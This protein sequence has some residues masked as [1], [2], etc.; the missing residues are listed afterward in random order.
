MGTYNPHYPRIIGQEWVPIRDTNYTP[1]PAANAIE[2]GHTFQLLQDRQVRDAR[3]Y[4]NTLPSA[5]NWQAF[6]A[7]VYRTGTEAATGP[8]KSVIIPCNFASTTGGSGVIL[9]GPSNAAALAWPNDDKVI[10]FNGAGNQQMA[11]FFNIDPYIQLLTNKRILDVQFLFAGDAHDNITQNPIG[12]PSPG[13][14]LASLNIANDANFNL[15]S[16]CDLTFLLSGGLGGNTR[17]PISAVSLG[18]VTDPLL[19]INGVQPWRFIDLQRFQSGSANRFFLIIRSNMSANQSI[20]WQYAALQ[21]IYCEERRLMVGGTANENGSFAPLLGAQVLPMRAIQTQTT[22]PVL[23]AGDYTVTLSAANFGNRLKD[24]TSSASFPLL[25]EVRQLYEIPTHRGVQVNIPI[26]VEDHLEATFGQESTQFLPQISLH[27]SGGP[28]T[29][30]HVYGR[31]AQAQVWGSISATQEIQDGLA[32]GNASWPW[33]RFYARRFGNTTRPLL[34]DSPSIGGSSVQITPAEFDALDEIAAGWKEVTLRFN[35]PPVMGSGTQPQWRWTASGENAGDRWEVL[36]AT[37]P[38]ISGLPGNLLNTVLS[39][40]QLSI[41]TYGQPVSGSSINLGWVPQ[42]APP[43]SATVDDQ[44]SDAT[45]IFAQEMTAPT[46]F[47]VAGADQAMVGIG[48]NCGINP[49]CIPSSIRYNTISWTPFSALTVRDTFERTVANGWGTADT[50]QVYALSG[51]ATSFSVGSGEGTISLNSVGAP[52]YATLPVAQADVDIRIDKVVLGGGITPAGAPIGIGLVARFVNNVNWYSARLVHNTN[53]TTQLELDKMVAGVRTVLATSTALPNVTPGGTAFTMRFQ[54]IGSMLRAKAW[55]RN[56]GFGVE[57]TAWTVVAY[58][59][60]FTAGG[61]IGVL[62]NLE[63]GNSNTLPVTSNWNDLTET[64]LTYDPDS[65][66]YMELQRMDTIDTTWTTIMK[67]TNLMVSG[68]KDYEARVG[69][70]SSYRLR[71][72]DVLGFT[73]AWSSTQSITMARPGASGGCISPGHLLMFTTNERQDGS[74]NLAYSSAWER[75]VEEGFTFPEA[76]FVQLQ[77]MYNRDF[78]TAFR[79]TERGGEQ[80]ER[81]ILVQAAAISPPTLADFTS[82]RDMAWEDVSYICV[83]DEDGNRWFATVLVP[84]G[85]VVF[86]RRIYMATVQIIEVTDT[87]SEVNP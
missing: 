82:L 1:S 73:G 57:P 22:D 84:S 39:P 23:S 31:Q 67:A 12:D 18:E 13:V 5:V 85:K 68:F 72:V 58:D 41:A 26:P 46:G 20:S 75:Q 7:Q 14:G 76:G 70:Q 81:D 59:T 69:I 50:G 87:P 17:T 10:I 56:G 6:T 74:S 29:E 43:T 42:Y 24:G 9:V 32:G 16:Y 47:T 36:G 15:V 71:F 25:N 38:A 19:A 34:L 79:P 78:F 27:T 52:R 49:C 53:N 4:I 66:G 61:D 45:L 33:V 83:R 44:T 30:P 62:F 63:P 40:N 8:I 3:F 60:S 64:R 35:T 2:R 54:V 28:L 65:S 48:L 86:Y 37:A 77:A 51:G 55:D 11:M 21:V 80:F